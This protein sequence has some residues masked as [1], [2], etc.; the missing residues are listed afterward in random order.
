[1]SKVDNL[2]DVIDID[3][4]EKI[5]PFSDLELR[6]IGIDDSDKFFNEEIATKGIQDIFAPI[7]KEI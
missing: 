1:M 6:A 2:T 4:L 3:E 7:T 5:K